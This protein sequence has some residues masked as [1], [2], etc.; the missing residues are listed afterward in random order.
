[1]CDEKATSADNQYETTRQGIQ[2]SPESHMVYELKQ[3]R[4]YLIRKLIIVQ[5]AIDAVS[6]VRY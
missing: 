3:Q 5:E 4:E 1:M 2:A 6:A